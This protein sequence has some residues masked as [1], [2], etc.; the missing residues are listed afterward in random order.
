[1]QPTSCAWCGEHSATVWLRLREETAD[2]DEVTRE[3]VLPAE[4]A[5]VW[6]SLTEP[7]RLPQWL[8]SEAEIELRPG[9]DLA[10]RTDDGET[11]TGWVEEAQAPSRLCFWWSADGDD[12]ST[13]V[14][15]DLEE[16]DDGATRL[17][18]T[19]SRPLALL[20]ALPA[21]PQMLAPPEWPRGR[22]TPS[23][24]RCQTPRGDADDAA[25]R[26]GPATPTEL[27]AQLPVSRQ[28]V[29]KHLGSLRT[30]DSCSSSRSG[31]RCATASRRS[32]CRTRWRG[33]PTWARSG[34]RAWPRWSAPW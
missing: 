9:G 14:E 15:L 24:P 33:W 26:A 3:T 6:R 23:S 27:A 4:P 25:V 1:M 29:A 7:E 8:G 32:R 28:A 21:A 31:A 17:R 12:D 34:T 30:P 2:A 10:V 13:R 18:V 19:E 5:D 16:A 22:R 20:A 11:R